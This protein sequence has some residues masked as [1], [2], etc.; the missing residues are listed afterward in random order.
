M[1]YWVMKAGHKSSAYDSAQ[2]L[3]SWDPTFRVTAP[4]EADTGDRVLLWRGGRG[5]GLVA[6]GEVVSTAEL[7][8]TEINLWK[9]RTRRKKDNAAT[10]QAPVRATVRFGRLMLSAPVSV[11][12][13]GRADL[14][15][16]AQRARAKEPDIDL[17]SVGLTD[18]QWLD[19]ARLAEEAQSPTEWP[20]RWNIPPGSIVKRAEL[21]EV[22]GGNPLVSVSSSGKT[23]NVF[24]FLKPGEQG[25]FGL[26]WDGSILRA[27]GHGQHWNHPSL[28]NLA[29]LTHQRCGVPLRVFMFHK[30]ECLYIGEFAID[31]KNPIEDWMVIGERSLPYATDIIHRIRK[32]IFRLRQLSGMPP[33]TCCKATFEGAPRTS[34]RLH[35][36][37]NQPADVLIRGLMTALERSPE[38]AASLG[39]MDEVQFLASALQRARRQRDLDDLRAAVEDHK[40]QEGDL[41]KLIQR[42]TWIFGGEFLPGTAR[43]N[44]TQRDELDLALLRPDGSLHGVELK[45]ATIEKLV[46]AH[47]SHMIPGPK[48][49]EAVCQAANYLRELDENRAQILASLGVDCRR[50]SM[51]VVIGHNK[52]VTTKATAKE[53]NETIRTYNSIHSRVTVITYDQL[54]DNAQRT[55]DLTVPPR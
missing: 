4:R 22:Y 51:T 11:D 10:E 43:R 7:T 14:G 42:M 23:P 45:R 24:L 53:V 52:F 21:H 3:E 19:L 31:E 49:H 16:V 54:V 30:S 39:E 13:L 41:Q 55:L 17:T 38:A 5:G 9:L 25:D 27:P 35:V 40:S 44:L 26:Q 48:V 15:H 29:A 12:S 33:D 50:A 1:K 46:I 18:R 32:P 8:T 20:A 2:N 37:S 36:L 34:I 28:E 47:R 6:I